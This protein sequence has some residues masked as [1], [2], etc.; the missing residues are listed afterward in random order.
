MSKSVQ[1]RDEP[2]R[3]W[4]LPRDAEHV[5]ALFRKRPIDHFISSY[6][7]FV[8]DLYICCL[9]DIGLIS[10][11]QNVLF[12]SSIWDLARFPMLCLDGCRDVGFVVT[13][14]L[15]T[16][17]I[18]MVAASHI[19]LVMAEE[20]SYSR[21]A[22]CEDDDVDFNN[23]PNLKLSD[24]IREVTGRGEICVFNGFNNGGSESTIDESVGFFPQASKLK[25]AHKRLR[26]STAAR[27][28]LVDLA[29]ANDRSIMAGS[30][31]SQRSVTLLNAAGG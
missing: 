12:A 26:Q 2:L 7:S 20:W 6:A 4:P 10:T 5:A 8:P 11:L 13:R 24:I 31:L 18:F 30:A 22:R 23:D 19:A 29:I 1:T 17:A 21:S 9:R 3:T 27:A 25:S 16:A 15:A 28:V 14:A